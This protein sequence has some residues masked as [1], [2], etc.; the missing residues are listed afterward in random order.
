M[1][2]PS[3]EM[4]YFVGLTLIAY[5]PFRDVPVKIVLLV[6]YRLML[7]I[8]RQHPWQLDVA[9]VSNRQFVIAASLS[10]GDLTTLEV[11]QRCSTSALQATPGASQ[12]G[13]WRIA[14]EP[15]S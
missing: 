1:C 6:E 13:T 14:S 10:F 15:A 4:D 12:M 9:M 7:V 2:H 8:R 5:R 11:R 3:D